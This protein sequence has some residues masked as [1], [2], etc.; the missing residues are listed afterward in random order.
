MEMKR[1]LALLFFTG[2]LGVATSLTGGK[3]NAESPSK[4]TQ[5]NSRTVFE[6]R[7]L[8]IFK[9]ASPSTCSECHLSG[10]DLKQYI[11]PS[12]GETFASLLKQGLID[13]KK[14]DESRLLK[15][16]RMSTPKSAILTKEAREREYEAFRE[17]IETAV[18]D[19]KLGGSPT[20]KIG[21]SVSNKVIQHTRIDSVIDSFT[22]NI[23][24]QEG[25]C[26][27]CHRPGTTENEGFYKQY[28]ERVRW[29]VPDDPEAT[30]RKILAQKLVDVE[31]PGQSLLLLKPMNKTPHGGGEKFVENDTT[32]RMFRGWID[33]YVKSV[34]GKYLSEKDLPE[35]TKV[36][37]AYTQ[38]ILE[39]NQTP[40]SWIKKSLT[41]EIYAWNTSLKDW[42]PKLIA[43]GDREVGDNRATNVL[44]FRVFPAGGP[45]EK[46]AWRQ[47]RLASGRYLLKYFVNT[48]PQI[49]KVALANS[50][51]FYQGKQEIISD[52]KTGWGGL[53]H[54]AVKI[55]TGK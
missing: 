50:P 24:S 21:P 39:V 3:L 1:T 11:L 36:G 28:G 44:V 49:S 13:A 16:M 26:M 46:A 51:A 52:W 37:L 8:P 55:D 19:A 43:T 9:S 14:P 32:Y 41:V 27:G 23:W 4:S 33:D 47:T 25:R 48:A 6:R 53:T 12:E 2:I 20:L 54:V 18:K 10:V 7:I 38:S 42:E 5:L 15:L 29:F 22:R 35:P 34:K 45:E 17:W 31:N 40:E 30:M